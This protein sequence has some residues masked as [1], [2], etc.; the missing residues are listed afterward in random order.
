MTNDCVITDK[1]VYFERLE[2]KK[3]AVLI[4]YQTVEIAGGTLTARHMQT[5]E[6]ISLEADTIVT[7]LGYVAGHDGL[8]RE[9]RRQP[10]VDLHEIGDGVRTAKIY[11]AIHAGYKLARRL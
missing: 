4:P 3:V 9:L 10:G 1:I 2:K 8:A 5:G 7:A 6:L 11:D